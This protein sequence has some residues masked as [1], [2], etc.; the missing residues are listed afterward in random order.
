MEQ[1]TNEEIEINLLELLY[2]VKQKIWIIILSGII[3]AAT[4]G[5]LTN[6]MVIPMYASK[7]KLYILS[8]STT[9]TSLADLQIGSQLTQDYMVLVKSRPVVEGVIESLDMELTYKQLLGY[10]TVSNP[11]N[12]RILEITIEYPDPYMAK[13]IADT[14]LE[15]SSERITSIM[16]SD[17]PTVVE[18]G[19]MDLNPTSP[20]TK[21]NIMIGGVL[22]VMLA[23]GIVLFL[24]ML[25]DTIKDSED[26]TRY[27]GLTTLG[28]IPVE[29][30]ERNQINIDK[31]KRKQKARVTKK[32]R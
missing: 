4:A 24:Y 29:E 18:E 2:I 12:T 8:K 11:S 31:K 5:I 19:Y 15:V 14:F 23:S 3:F 7:A 1:N 21:M 9:L 6:M 16:D 20:N 17:K 26:V 32:G 27:L 10:I 13:K 22:G 28:L 25:D 30:T